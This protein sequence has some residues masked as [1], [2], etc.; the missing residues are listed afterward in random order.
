MGPTV[1]RQRCSHDPEDVYKDGRCRP[2][3]HARRAHYLST[4][5]G[6]ATAEA[7]QL[8]YRQSERGHQVRARVQRAYVARKKASQ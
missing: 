3:A 6:K 5:H 8:R 4:P 7:A 2:C 1:A